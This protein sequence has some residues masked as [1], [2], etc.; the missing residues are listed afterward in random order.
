MPPPPQRVFA[1]PRQQSL[2]LPAVINPFIQ[3][4][5]L[6]KAA[7]IKVS[8]SFLVYGLRKYRELFL[9]SSVNGIAEVAHAHTCTHI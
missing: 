5:H 4:T 8:M 7:I 1:L 6:T 2:L 9:Y 3:D